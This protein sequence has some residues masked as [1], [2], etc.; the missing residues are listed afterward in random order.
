[1]KSSVP[2][3]SDVWE[4]KKAL[5]AALYKDEEWPLK[6]VIKK[7][8]SE[9]FNPSETQ[10]RSRLKKWRVTKPS[11]QT[12]ERTKECVRSPKT[13]SCSNNNGSPNSQTR[14]RL[15]PTP[16]EAPA[17]QSEWSMPNRA[18][19]PHSLPTMP[20]PFGQH[21]QDI[22]TFWAP[23]SSH[24]SPLSSPGKS[25][26]NSLA[27]MTISTSTYE[28]SQ[29]SAFVDGPLLDSTPA[30]TPTFANSPYALDNNS[31][32]Q[33]PVPTTTA[34]PPV[35]W[36]MPQC[37]LLPIETSS[38]APSMPLYTTGPLTPPIDPMMLPMAPQTPEFH[39]CMKSWKR[40]LSSPYDPDLVSAK[41]QQPAKSLERKVSRSSNISTSQYSSGVVTPTS[42]FFHGQYPS[43]CSPGYPYPGPESLVHRPS[44]GL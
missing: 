43:A 20:L 10:L 3:S 41:L 8:R 31:C 36:A 27:S 17:T 11:R 22:R 38:Q 4:E 19:G 25:R 44:I 13:T 23:A 37:Y 35:Q 14:S 16:A 5:I 2:I 18:D 28:P 29:T 34:V 6:Q 30:M 39:D 7:I 26:V 21:Q 42:P 1:M 33:T 9:N 32:L 24:S 12:R 40:T 15:P